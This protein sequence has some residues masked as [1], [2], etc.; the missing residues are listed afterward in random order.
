MC[1]FCE[2]NGLSEEDIDCND[3]INDKALLK[4]EKKDNDFKQ[5]LE[6][7]IPFYLGIQIPGKASEEQ[8]TLYVDF[9]SDLFDEAGGKNYVNPKTGCVTKSLCFETKINYCPMCGRKF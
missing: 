3:F 5:S 6:I 9:E 4:I 7:C 8:P 1:K 2:W